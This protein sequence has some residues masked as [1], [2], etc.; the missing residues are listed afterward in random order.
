M[1]SVEEKLCKEV[2]NMNKEDQ[3]R[4]IQWGIISLIFLWG[5]LSQKKKSEENSLS[6]SVGSVWYTTRHRAALNE[7]AGHEQQRGGKTVNNFYYLL[8]VS[9]M[10]K[11]RNKV[12]LLNYGEQ[13]KICRTI[14]RRSC[15]KYWRS[16]TTVTDSPDADCCGVTC[17][18]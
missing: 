3:E 14:L 9:F 2:L 5:F 7:K 18:Q 17:T 6:L 10:K 16:R 13:C 4:T 12:L 1:I 8:K 11:S 15:R